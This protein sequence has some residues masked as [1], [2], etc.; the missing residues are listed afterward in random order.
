MADVLVL[1]ASWLNEQAQR[2]LIRSLCHSRDSIDLA[3]RDHE[4]PKLYRR[5]R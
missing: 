3:A 1:E 5:R 2:P 4:G